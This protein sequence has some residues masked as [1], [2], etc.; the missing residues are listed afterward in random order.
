MTCPKCEELCIDLIG[1]EHRLGTRA[2]IAENKLNKIKE[3]IRERNIALNEIIKMFVNSKRHGEKEFFK[4]QVYQTREEL[5][6]L[7]SL[8]DGEE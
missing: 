4:G 8:L 1:Q 5:K 3:K 6:F 2:E 7:K